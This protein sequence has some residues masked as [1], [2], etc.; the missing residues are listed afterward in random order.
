MSGPWPPA[1]LPGLHVD[2]SG[3]HT[4][5]WSPEY[6]HWNLPPVAEFTCRCGF[7]ESAVGEAVRA[8]VATIHRIHAKTC[9]LAQKETARG[10]QS[11]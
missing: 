6:G 7:R 8:F 5:P 4:R 1:D 10:A 11:A 3:T 9:S 2:C